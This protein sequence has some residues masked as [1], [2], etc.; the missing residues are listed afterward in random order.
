MRNVFVNKLSAQ[1]QFERLPKWDAI[2]W[3]EMIVGWNSQNGYDEDVTLNMF[4]KIVL[5][6][7]NPYGVFFTNV[8]NACTI[9][10]YLGCE[11]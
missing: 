5:E 8:L 1:R 3:K 2:S 10:T 9:L 11:K 7:M 4:F 6:N